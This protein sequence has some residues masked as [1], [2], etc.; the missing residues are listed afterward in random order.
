MKATQTDKLYGV[1]YADY[2]SS[3]DLLLTMKH[4]NKTDAPIDFRESYRRY[5][6]GPC[7]KNVC[8]PAALDELSLPNA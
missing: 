7:G 6:E 8:Y 2:T 1:L 5:E 3:T 4:S